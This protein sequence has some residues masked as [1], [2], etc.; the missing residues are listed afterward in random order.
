MGQPT[1]LGSFPANEPKLYTRIT[2][3][4]Y[5]RPNP[6]SNAK[7]ETH[8]YIRLP[9]PVELTDNY[10]TKVNGNVDLD[11]TASLLGGNLSG[12]GFVDGLIESRRGARGIMQVLSETGLSIAALLP[13]SADTNFGRLAQAELGVVRNP[14]T[15]AIFEGVNLRQHSLSFRISPQNQK[16]ADQIRNIIEQIK[17]R[18][19]PN[20]NP[21]GFALEYPDIVSVSFEGIDRK[22]APMIRRSFITA[23]TPNYAGQGFVAFYNGAD[24][25]QPV[26]IILS[27]QLQELEIVTKEVID[28]PDVYGISDPVNAAAAGEG[29]NSRFSPERV[30]GLL[31]GRV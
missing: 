10:N 15:T 8:G 7:I 1:L 27:M 11:L 4:K 30:T 28:N 19:H 3:H 12:K 20:L 21:S 31:P 14:H 9:L 29:L 24:R 2:F 23:F 26:D 6:R 22:M 13:T 25:A 17:K 18:M 16:E 5:I